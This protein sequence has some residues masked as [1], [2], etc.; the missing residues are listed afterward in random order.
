MNIISSRVNNYKSHLQ[1]LL[2]QWRIVSIATPIVVLII[3][4]SRFFGLL[5]PL[6]LFT[7]DVFFTSR[8]PQIQ[9]E[10]IVIVG[11]GEKD[12]EKIGTALISDEIYADLLEKLLK[13]E[14]RAI[15][16]DIY[17]DVPI[18]PGTDKLEEVFSSSKKIIGIE[19]MIGNSRQQRV[20]PSPI[21]KA[22]NQI[23]FNDV[24]LD[25]DNKI[26]RALLAL[27]DKK[28]FSLAMYTSLMYLAQE[29]INL[30]I[31]AENNYWQLNKTIFI[32]LERNDGGYANADSGGYQILLDYRGNT[33]HFNIVS[34][35]DVLENKLPAHWGKD[36][37]IFI[38]FVGES[39]QDIHLTPYTNSPD[40]RM[41]GVEIHANIASQIISSVIDDRPLIKTWSETKENIWI[42]I[43]TTIGALITWIFRREHNFNIGIILLIIAIMTLISICYVAFL[44]SWW[45]PI[46]PPLMGLLGSA[47]SVTIYNAYNASK[48]RQTFGRY[49]STEIVNTLLETREGVTLGGERRTITILTSDLRGFTAL[50]EKLAPE[51]VVKILNFYLGYM[52]NII[53]EYQGTIDEFMGDGILVLFGAPVVRTDDPD[54]AVACA[55]AMQLAM[56]EVNQQMHKWGYQSLKMGIGINTG[57]VVVGNIGSE[58]RTKYGVVGSEV[59]L[60]YRIESY[61]KGREILISE[62]TYKHL[63]CQADIAE[64]KQVFPKGVPQPIT[65]YKIVGLEGK[66][67][68]SLP[69]IKE[70]IVTLNKPFKIKYSLLNDKDITDKIYEGIV[71]D[72][73]IKGGEK[74][75]YINLCDDQVILPEPLNNL[76][77]RLID[78]PNSEDLYG[79]V[80]SSNPEKKIFKLYFTYLSLNTEKIIIRKKK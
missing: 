74:G 42:I 28:A 6:E 29:N 51:V 72:I 64:E 52:A 69:E 56:D 68:L 27:P 1:S 43:W 63:Q 54:R 59:N 32:P 9:D 49:L 3:I 57:E 48:V 26:R 12:V 46:I 17:R 2:W 8:A 20:K 73:L 39:F 60:T 80:I 77:L 5:Q 33:N 40:Q 7:Y 78:Y 36:K 41:P 53:T 71:T 18:A 67:S 35:F 50:S 30:D 23:G 76:K 4:V 16:L 65:I 25:E 37:I 19:K 58:K 10:R 15:G 31:T 11:I 34:L 22:N 24:I 62:T 47:G 66:Y 13:K 70:K 75:A 14:P 55:I 44:K 45:I 21:L 38:G 79:K 61:T